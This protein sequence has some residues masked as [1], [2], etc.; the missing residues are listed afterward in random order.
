MH[1]FHAYIACI[2]YMHTLHAYITCIQYIHTLHADIHYIHYRYYM[3]TYITYITYMTY[4]TYII[5]HDN[6]WHDMRL[7]Y[8]QRKNSIYIYM[9]SIHIYI[10]ICIY[11][12]ID[13]VGWGKNNQCWRMESCDGCFAAEPQ[14]TCRCNEAADFN[15][16][17]HKWRIPPNGKSTKIMGNPW[18][19]NGWFM[20]NPYKWMIWEHP[21]FRK[22]PL[23]LACCWNGHGSR[24]GYC[25]SPNFGWRILL[26][27]S[28]SR[29]LPQ[30]LSHTH[31]IP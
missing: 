23:S 30:I 1:T 12:Y 14:R 27:W 3:Q 13:T 4:M 6:T 22:P 15:G 29:L 31:N 20:E 5:L 17:F 7:H 26:Q 10:H 2:H 28:K 19:Y 8:I 16:D 21:Y 18:F 25:N 9:Y 24:I 11:L